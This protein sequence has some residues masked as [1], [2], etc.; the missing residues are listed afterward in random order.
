MKM[1]IVSQT[2][3]IKHMLLDDGCVHHLVDCLYVL[4]HTLRAY[5]G[6]AVRTDARPLCE[7]SGT[8]CSPCKDWD[9]YVFRHE[10]KGY[11]EVL[12]EMKSY[13]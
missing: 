7:R 8:K 2:D 3:P 12:E 1:I 9:I 13:A 11:K 10:V 4:A 5:D 6:A